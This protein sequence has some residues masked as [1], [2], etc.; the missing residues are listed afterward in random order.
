MHAGI[1]SIRK[2]RS[3]L[4]ERCNYDKTSA[5]EMRQQKPPPDTRAQPLWAAALALPQAGEGLQGYLARK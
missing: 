5:A 1:D 2:M 3:E 4:E